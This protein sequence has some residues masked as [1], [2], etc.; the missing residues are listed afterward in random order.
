MA[1]SNPH[2]WHRIQ[3]AF[4]QQ[5]AYLGIRISSRKF[6]INILVMAAMLGFVSTVFT[7]LALQWPY[8]LVIIGFFITFFIV[9]GGIYLFLDLQAES[10]GKQVEKILPDAL[11]LIASNIKAGLTTERAMLVS[12]RPEFGPFEGEMKRV[13]TRILSGTPV[14]RAILDISK[15]IKSTLVERTMWLLARGISSGGEIAD[16]LMQLSRN[17][18]TQLALQSEAKA[19]ISIYVILIFFSAAFGGP[20]LYAVSSFIVAVMSAQMS[21]Q[22][23]IDPSVIGA[24]GGRFGGLSSFVGGQSAI[25][26]PEFVFFFAQI[27]LFVGGIFASLILGSI[28]TGKEKDGVKYIPVILFFS[29]GLF[30]LIRFVLDT[31]FGSLLLGK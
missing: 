9:I 31:A 17:L 12:A 28:S 3:D 23:S 8:F 5:F 24:A 20:A 18:R 16:L 13:S 2:I 26:S 4:E 15:H 1:S 6:V 22:P 19:S 11:Q 29:Y 21:A 10:R 25:I 30:Y 7:S 14:E 27:I